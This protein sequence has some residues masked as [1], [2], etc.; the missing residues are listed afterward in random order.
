MRRKFVAALR[1]ADLELGRGAAIQFRR[2]SGAWAPAPRESAEACLEQTPPRR[3]RFFEPQSNARPRGD[4]M[5]TARS[6]SVEAHRTESLTARS[7]TSPS[8]QAFQILRL[9]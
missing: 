5:S 1:G 2:A 3:L 9:G 4:A 8:Y 7:A 6:V